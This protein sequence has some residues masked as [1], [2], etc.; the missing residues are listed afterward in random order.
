M[1]IFESMGHAQVHVASFAFESV[2]LSQF[3]SAVSCLTMGG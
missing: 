2:G 3:G 1:G